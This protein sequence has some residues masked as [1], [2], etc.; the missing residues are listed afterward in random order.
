MTGSCAA[1]PS[2]VYPR[3]RS[4]GRSRG[5]ATGRVVISMSSTLQIEN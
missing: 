3:V 2:A 1:E 4:L 5:S